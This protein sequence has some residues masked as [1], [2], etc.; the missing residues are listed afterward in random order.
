MIRRNNNPLTSIFASIGWLFFGPSSSFLWKTV[1]E[2]P[3][4][5]SL[6]EGVYHLL[7]L[8][9]AA[10]DLDFN[11]HSQ[12]KG[13]INAPHLIN[14][15][16]VF[17]FP[18]VFVKFTSFFLQ[19]IGFVKALI[20]SFGWVVLLALIRMIWIDSTFAYGVIRWVFFLALKTSRKAKRQLTIMLSYHCQVIK[21]S[22]PMMISSSRFLFKG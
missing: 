9:L 12:S 17:S 22:Y 7:D 8:L 3:S 13:G 5:W 19:V 6:L 16:I 1:Y 18:L 14:R 15:K 10:K 4:A 11:Y 2:L 20:C 21:P